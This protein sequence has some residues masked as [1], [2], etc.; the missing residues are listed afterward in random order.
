MT[1]IGPVPRPT[2]KPDDPKVSPADMPQPVLYLLASIAMALNLPLPSTDPAD[3]RA[4]HRLLER[5]TTHVRILLESLFSHPDVPLNGDAADV[6]AYIEQNPV[7]YRT[8]D[9]QK[10]ADH[11][12]K[13]VTQ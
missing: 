4:F 3:E 13:V 5:R 6:L 12:P 2:P 11:A 10:A 7:T 9:E 8:F 1:V